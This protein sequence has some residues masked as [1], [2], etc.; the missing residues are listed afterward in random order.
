MLRCA[1]SARGHMVPGID[2]VTSTDR[3][4]FVDVLRGFA[5]IGVFG[6]NLLIFSGYTY[7]SE[8]QLSA[9]PSPNADAVIHALETIFIENKFMG[10]F[11][12]LFGV[13][14]WLFLERANKRGVK[15]TQL[16]YRRIAW[17]FVIGAIHGWLFWCFDI[18]RFYAMWALF[19]PLF[20]KVSNR[21]LLSSALFFS[22]IAPGLISATRVLLIGPN[23]PDRSLDE[24]A[25]QVFAA[26]PYVDFL[27]VNWLYDWYLTLE[28]GQLSYQIGIFGRLLLG[29]FAARNLLFVDRSDH[30]RLYL[31][32]MIFGSIFGIAGNVIMAGNYL[33]TPAAGDF[34]LTF[35]RSFINQFGL[36]SRTLAYA[37][38]LALLFQKPWWGKLLSRLAAVGRMALT[39]YLMQTLFGLWLFYGFMPGPNLMGR[40]GLSWLVPIW[41][42]GYLLQVLLCSLWLRYFR[43]GPA[44]W[45]WRSLTYGNLQ[46]FRT[47]R[48]SSR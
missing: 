32:L 2:R 20:V 5:L 8:A 38:A 40:V 31:M 36:L 26:G 47:V 39:C 37:A 7:M 16:F 48:G 44:E 23:V 4:E 14:F 11:S 15:G 41:I 46:P 19:L 35:A 30:R 25:L 17:L 45:L 43:F 6:A 12:F 13:S 22:F 24:L 18:L 28:W 10:L 34:F 9:L 42:A 21:T 1:A 3:L 33:P 27:R 29:L